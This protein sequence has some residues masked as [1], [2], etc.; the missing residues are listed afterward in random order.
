MFGSKNNSVGIIGL[1]IIGS[2]VAD[3]LRNADYSVF[4]WNR[5]IKPAPNFMASPAEVAEVAPVIQIFVRDAE[6]LIAVMEDMKPALTPQHVVLCHSTVNA[7]AI[8]RAAAIAAEVGAG[9]LDAPFTGSK[10]AAEQ[11]QLIYYIGGEAADLDKA[12]TVLGISGKK[13]ITLG[14]PGDATVLKIATNLISA[15]VVEALAEA[16][17]ITK[18]E[19]IEISKLQEALVDNA[20]SSA[21]I[22]M[23]LPTMAAR[24]YAP[25]F[26]LKNMLKDARYA[27]AIADE[28]GL[29][30]PVLNAAAQAMDRG[31]RSGQGD[32]D[33]AVVMENFSPVL[34]GL[35][36][37]A[38]KAK[39]KA[40]PTPLP[41]P[42]PVPVAKEEAPAAISL[43][44]DKPGK[45]EKEKDKDA[46]KP[47][48]K[49]TP[50]SKDKDK[51]KGKSKT[52]EADSKTSRHAAVLPA[53]VSAD[54]PEIEAKASEATETPAL[55]EAKKAEGE[56]ATDK[57]ETA[58]ATEITPEA[59]TSESNETAKQTDESA[60]AQAEVVDAGDKKEE[61]A[62]TAVAVIASAESQPPAA[63]D[64]KDKDTPAAKGDPKGTPTELSAALV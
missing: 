22:H 51:G 18:A 50:K 20:N 35:E 31:V 60:V 14:K 41:E 38:A 2:R 15:A 32:F 45:P 48:A 17:A 6:A 29:A 21:L 23:K 11:G 4:V 62:S 57:A 53:S 24:S 52:A 9:F 12:R 28:K 10:T 47:L 37:R 63:E 26:S 30:L 33:Y 27:Q 46:S 36:E 56:P 61:E 44:K 55:A 13:I 5:S 1:G 7:R 42:P 59:K 39:P 40:E 34:R 8:R 19:G 25:H 3:R 43:E 16:M 58:V 49:D 64:K 54:E